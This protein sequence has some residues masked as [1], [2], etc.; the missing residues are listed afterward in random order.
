MLDES[1]FQ[2][3]DDYYLL[4]ITEQHI[5]CISIRDKN[6]V[7]ELATSRLQDV[8]R[9]PNGLALLASDGTKASLFVPDPD[10]MDGLY[11]KLRAVRQMR[12]YLSH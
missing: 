1:V 3:E 11:D 4:F 12:S 10:D 5:A 7:W 2:A 8:Q 6:V 9:A